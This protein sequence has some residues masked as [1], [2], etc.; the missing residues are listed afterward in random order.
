MALLT[1]FG[2]D[3]VWNNVLVTVLTFIYVFSLVAL[4]NLLVSRYR[5]PQDLSRKISHIGAGTLIAF[6]P[7]YNGGTGGHWTVYL[8]VSIFV[9]WIVLLTLKGFTADENDEAVKTMTRTGDRHELLRGPL[10]FVIVGTICGTLYFGT[11]AGVMAMAALGWGDGLAPMIGTRFGRMK[12]K[13]L[14]EKSLEGSLTVF[15]AS[16]LAG[17]FFVW[18]IVP[19]ALNP[20]RIILLSLIAAVAEGL[21][22]KDWDNFLIPVAV[23]GASQFIL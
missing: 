13:V 14:S 1:L 15:I 3:V 23:I 22:P 21:S 17:I 5:F 20:G 2:L 16:A 10:Y 6:W 18:L 4:M 11:F 9:L 7:L 19:A 8:N 12:Y